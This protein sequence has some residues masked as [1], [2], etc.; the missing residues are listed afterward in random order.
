LK[1]LIVLCACLS[2]L[3]IACGGSGDES[4]GAPEAGTDESEAPVKDSPEKAAS[5][6]RLEGTFK[7]KGSIVSASGFLAP[8][9]GDAIKRDWIFE[10]VCSSGSCDVR[11]KQETPGGTATGSLS[12][13]GEGFTGTTSILGECMDSETGEVIDKKG[14]KGIYRHD[15][16][17]VDTKEDGEELLVTRIKGSIA[18][19]SEPV[20]SACADAPSGRQRTEYTGTLS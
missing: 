13:G 8:L 16:R 3:V 18:V 17:I 19:T 4:G 1:R 14:Y 2:F 7:I 12:F 20:G 10:P 6:P 11:L 15:I 5:E 9:K